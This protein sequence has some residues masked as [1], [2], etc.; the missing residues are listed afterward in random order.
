M[1][2]ARLRQQLLAERVQANES[3]ERVRHRLSRTG[4]T[5]QMIVSMD[6]ALAM[7]MAILGRAVPAALPPRTTVYVPSGSAVRGET[8]DDTE[9]LIVEDTDYIFTGDVE[10]ETDDSCVGVW[11]LGP[12]AKVEV[13]N[14]SFTGFRQG[15]VAQGHEV[16]EVPTEIGLLRV[17]DCEINGT[18]GQGIYASR[19]N[20]IRIRRNALVDCGE[21][22]FLD[23]AIYIQSDCGLNNTIVDNCSFVNA[24]SHA[25]QMRSG[26]T[27]VYN[28]VARCGIGLQLGGGDTP[29]VGG[30][31]GTLAGNV[32]CE[33]RDIPVDAGNRGIGV[34]VGNVNSVALASNLLWQNAGTGPCSLW[35]NGDGILGQPGVGV[36]LAY[37]ANNRVLNW[38]WGYREDGTVTTYSSLDWESA[39][40]LPDTAPTLSL[41]TLLGSDW[42]A[43]LL[44]RQLNAALCNKAVLTQEP[45]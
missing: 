2:D 8:V 45:A 37:G 44:S 5:Q 43:K 7:G 38:K 19:C 11:A 30:V 6:T 22:G 16:D 36:G 23:H 31:N 33:G 21:A 20:A 26:G 34:V 4:M 10:A 15:I 35:L 1:T 14:C 12:F 41:D 40:A 39:M 32:I 25:L 24:G 17:L 18:L 3:W 29:K 9:E 27:A 13:K 42:I 28:F